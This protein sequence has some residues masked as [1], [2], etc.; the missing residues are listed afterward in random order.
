VKTAVL[1]INEDAVLDDF[2]AQARAPWLAL[3]VAARGEPV[4]SRMLQPVP[5]AIVIGGRASRALEI[6]RALKRLAGGVPLILVVAE[7]TEGQAIEA[8]R[9]GAADYLRLP[10]SPADVMAVIERIAEVS[11]NRQATLAEGPCLIGRSAVVR[12]L[13][14]YLHKVAASECN[15][16]VTGETGTGKELAT[17]II[18]RQSRRSHRTLVCVNCAA[19]PDTLLESELFGHE[20]GAF[21]GAN[22]ARDGQF[23]AADGGTI[24]LDEI[25]EMTPCAQAKILRVIES[26]QVQRLGARNP[27]RVDVRIVAATNQDLES[28]V[29]A[30]E[31]R[32]DLYFRLN[33]ARVHLPPLRAR[34]EDIPILLHHFMEVQ[35]RACG[36]D[37]RGFT[38][39]AM[40]CLTE[41]SWPGNVRELKNIVESTF[42]GAVDAKIST[43]D[44]PAW[45]L[46][47]A[48]GE[49]T[50]SDKE[51]LLQALRVTRWNKSKAAQQLKWS[52]MTVYRKMARY[53]ISDEAP[54]A[55]AEETSVPRQMSAGQS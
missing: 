44:L 10:V 52:R 45:F 26:K 25:G 9:L 43:S 18:H 51:R 29:G 6:T 54:D 7:S 19:I 17:E 22:S 3:R 16:L 24:F 38:D 42:V 14:T 11:A 27:V 32:R 1:L 13:R 15:V 8:L 20:R 23:N 36:R 39:E 50:L 46:H 55:A 12:D 48:Q 31:F 34:K 33:V 5:Q 2:F 4:D 37:I 47:R 40:D 30:N 35:N 28:R 49:R 41:Y 21:T 53:G